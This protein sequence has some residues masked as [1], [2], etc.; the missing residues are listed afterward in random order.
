MKD[1]FG[2][3]IHRNAYSDI[4]QKTDSVLYQPIVNFRNLFLNKQQTINST[5]NNYV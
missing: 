5:Q 3:K 1:I 2:I 4:E